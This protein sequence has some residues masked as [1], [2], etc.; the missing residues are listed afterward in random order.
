MFDIQFEN[1]FDCDTKP[2]M[3][4][5]VSV[6]VPVHG[7]PEGRKGGLLPFPLICLGYPRLFLVLR[8]FSFK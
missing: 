6:A 5:F 2:R 8:L 7:R 3:T 4:D 1:K